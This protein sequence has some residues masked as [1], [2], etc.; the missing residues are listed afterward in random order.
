MAPGVRIF[1]RNH[2]TERLSL[3]PF[4]YNSQLG[5]VA[6]DT[7][8]LGVLEIGHDAWLGERVIVTPGCSRIGIGAVVGA[9]AVVTKDVPDFGIVAGNPAKLLRFRFPADVQEVIRDS[10]WWEHSAEDCARH[11]EFI[12]KPVDRQE[13]F[14]NPL[15]AGAA[16]SRSV[17]KGEPSEIS[18]VA[19]I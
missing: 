2:P 3:H 10:K 7:I 4:F 16:R 18:G 14:L 15:L 5:W 1:L 8:A 19:G 12:I 6:R 11:M 9:G 13:L 17:V